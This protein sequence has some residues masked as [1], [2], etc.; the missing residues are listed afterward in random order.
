MFMKTVSY[1]DLFSDREIKHTVY[2][3]LTKTRAMRNLDIKD[4]LE[5]FQS[6]IAG[7]ERELTTREKQDAFALIERLVKVSY[8]IRDESG[9]WRQSDDIYNDFVDTPLYDAVIFSIFE[10]TQ[11]M[12]EFM[13]GIMPRD[14]REQMAKEMDKETQEELGFAIPPSRPKVPL[15][16]LQKG[17]EIS[18]D[19]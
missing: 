15:D 6:R 17:G 13:T 18:S 1:E 10:S 4:D 9:E 8:G 3:H 16:R 14:V 2:F 19:S 7:E 11:S 5:S 12:S